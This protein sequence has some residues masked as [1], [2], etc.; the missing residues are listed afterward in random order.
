MRPSPYAAIAI[1]IVAVSFASI[2]IRWSESA[3]LVIAAYRLIFA[4]L[5]VLPFAL[6]QQRKELRGLASRDLIFMVGVGGILAA[7]FGLWMTS[8]KVQG[9]TVASSVVLVTSHPILVGVVSHLVLR[10]RVNAITSAGIA[11]GLAG[12]ALIGVGDYGLSSSTFGGDLLALGG[13]VMAGLYILAGRHFRQ[14]ISLLTYVLIVYASAA[15]LLAVAAFASDG[16]RPSGDLWRELGIFLVMA[17]VSQI[18]GHTLYN[19]ALKYVTAP[20]VS[21][22]LVGEPIGASILAWLLLSE[23][24]TNLVAIGSLA[25]VFGIYLTARGQSR[26]AQMKRAAA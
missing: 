5:I 23:V 25:A 22:S 7:H 2:F 4:T 13:G 14:R 6:A 12:V 11:I 1:A 18:G 26:I 16:M 10:E 15:I 20:V 8:L 21:V 9:V 24:P 17:L 19:W 3:P